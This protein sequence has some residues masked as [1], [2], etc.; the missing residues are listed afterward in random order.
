[1]PQVKL[2]DI[3]LGDRGRKDMGDIEGLAADFLE[4]GQITAIT[5]R[6]RRPDE[7]YEEPF[8]LVAGG[9]RYRAALML[10]WEEIEATFRNDEI[11]DRKHRI[12]ELQ[13]NVQR[14]AMTWQEETFMREEI[15]RLMQEENP[16]W[17]QSDTAEHLGLDKSMVSKELSLVKAMETDPDIAKAPTKLAAIRLVDYKKKVA[18]RVAS[19]SRS[20]LTSLREKLVTADMR[21]F[22]RQLPAH[23]VD[24][25]FTDF[26]FGIDYFENR[27]EDG[28]LQSRYED[29]AETLRDLLTDV[30]PQIVRFTKPSGWLALMMGS[31]HYEFLRGLIEDCCATHF[32]YRASEKDA[33][34]PRG[35]DDHSCRWL[36]AEDPEWIW[37]RPN[38]RNPS[39]WP[40]LHQQNQYEKICVVNMGEA[41]ISPLGRGKGNVLVHDAVY[42]DRIHEMQRPH[43]L[44]RD[45]VER[46]SLGGQLVVDLC[47]GSGSALAA[48]ADLQRDFA[49]CD[50]NP[51]NLEPAL[52]HV[53][54]YYR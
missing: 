16:G 11:S 39:M 18:E 45:I 22:A 30:I 35:T 25:C 9:R 7:D 27:T 50:L 12:L 10:G 15:H 21:D 26:P 4:N 44:C 5:I 42:T 29:S 54:Q 43:S 32:E 46:L 28:H 49:G 52:G 34:C 33:Y 51:K 36:K 48:A 1:M 17:T 6:P 41:V 31:T 20:S 23:S 3:A 14:E 40:E 53:G 19:V 38:S 8:V 2:T 24:L 37:Y 47:F 13:E